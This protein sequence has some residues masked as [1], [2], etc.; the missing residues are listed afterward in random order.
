LLP[1]AEPVQP[2]WLIANEP[3]PAEK[4]GEELLVEG[5]LLP[6][7]TLAPTFAFELVADVVFPEK[8]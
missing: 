1:G 5:E 2:A 7:K 4:T 3:E 8:E 6:E